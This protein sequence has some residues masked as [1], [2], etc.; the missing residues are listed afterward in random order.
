M[1]H[2]DN[3]ELRSEKTRKIINTV[4]P[5]LTR[6][7]ISFI[8]VILILF[9]G[10]ILFSP[11]MYMLSF[12][13]H[14][15]KNGDVVFY[16]PYDQLDNIY[17][18]MEGIIELEGYPVHIYDYFTVKIKDIDKTPIVDENGICCQ[19]IGSLKQTKTFRVDL[20]PDMKGHGNLL[21]KTSSLWKRICNT[22]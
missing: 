8:T 1:Q 12:D 15:S 17:I 10:F 21:I 13:V 11:H 14:I 20:Y 2:N 7:G 19:I 3:I 6:C 5:I 16:V 9:I 18:G 22:K 4:P